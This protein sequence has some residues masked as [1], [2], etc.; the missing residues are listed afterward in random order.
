M[1]S[2]ASLLFRDK[3][4][5][6]YKSFIPPEL[7]L[8]FDK[9]CLVKKTELI[10]GEDYE[11]FKYITSVSDACSRLDKKG[12][13][14]IRFKKLYEE[15]KSKELLR[16]QGDG[17]FFTIANNLT[18]ERYCEAIKRYERKAPNFYLQ[19]H[20]IEKLFPDDEEIILA[21]DE[22]IFNPE[23]NIY[24]D[25]A[26]HLIFIRAL[27]E[28]FDKSDKIELDFSFL[29]YAGYIEKEEAENLF[30]YFQKVMLRRINLDYQIYGYL[31]KDD[32]QITEKLK[33]KIMEYDED[34][35]LTKVLEPLLTKLNYE[36]VKIVESHGRNEFGSDILPFRYKNEL[37]FYEYY[38]LQ[39]KAVKIHGISSQDGNAGEIISQCMQAFAISFIDNLDNERKNIDKFFIVTN[40]EITPDAKRVIE[41][42]IEKNRSIIFLDINKIVEL[43][44]IKELAS[45][46]LFYT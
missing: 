16:Y 13:T 17:K 36:N 35:F 29:V 21:F 43:V 4:V 10:E 1:G 14:F 2:Y 18:Y 12:L 6:S 28:V 27:L 19:S 20:E 25:E 44:K 39:A 24:F 15:F 26:G 34:D 38:A 40:K 30:E 5:N 45:F 22:D 8:L 9:N 7:L 11:T 37:G 33:Q 42:A 41:E 31:L 3:E 32:P 23:S 46:I